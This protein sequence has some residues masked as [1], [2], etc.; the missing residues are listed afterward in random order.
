MNITDRIIYM[1][2]ETY[3]NFQSRLMPTVD[4]SRIIGVRT[5][6]L[7][8][9][10]KSISDEEASEFMAH[11]PHTYYEEDNLH[12]FLIER[13]KDFDVCICELERFLPYVDNWATCDSM[14]PKV[15]KKETAS[16]LFH[17]E[18]WIKSEKC[19]TVRYAIGLLM[20]FYLEGEFSPSYLLKVASVKSKEYYVKMM[21]AWYFA[22]ALA[23]QYESAVVYIEGHML[24]KW[25][26]KKTVQKACESYRISEEKKKYLRSLIC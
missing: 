22:T 21:V 7:R 11:L 24:D 3:R 19:Y 17:I 23:K 2:D 13:I 26:E 8:A 12:A 9:L 6:H 16:L 15:L 4:K 25:T 20:K 14:T 18:R 10:S 5:P 1:R